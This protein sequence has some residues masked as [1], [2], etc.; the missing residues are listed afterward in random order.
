MHGFA[1]PLY[2]FYLQWHP[3]PPENERILIPQ[4]NHYTD[5]QNLCK[6]QYVKQLF[7]KQLLVYYKMS[8]IDKPSKWLLFCCVSV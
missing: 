1:K 2:L 4:D 3:L 8:V 5:M 6:L 7:T